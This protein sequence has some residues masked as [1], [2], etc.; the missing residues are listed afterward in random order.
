[1]GSPDG[2]WTINFKKYIKEGIS[3]LEHI[4]GMLQ[5]YKTPIAYKDEPESYNSPFIDNEDHRLYQ[6]C[7]GMAQW[8]V[9]IGRI[10]IA[11]ALT[12]YNRFTAAPHEGHLDGVLQ[13]WGYLKKHPTRCISITHMIQSLMIDTC[14]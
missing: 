12:S 7:I 9:T 10:D 3:H 14:N 5:K 4:T 1:M 11:F 2:H 6:T 13:I 8:L